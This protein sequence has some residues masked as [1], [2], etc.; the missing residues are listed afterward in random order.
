MGM[1]L[2]GLDNYKLMSLIYSRKFPEEFK[3]SEPTIKYKYYTRL[4]NYLK[5]ID[6]DKY[7]T[8]YHVG[9][10]FDKNEI[11]SALQVLLDYFVSIEHY[12]KCAVIVQYKDLLI[13]EQVYDILNKPTIKK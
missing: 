3:N 11:D 8:L 5:N 2:R 7:E 6:I 10:S 4:F 13:L 12:E 1:V 9:E